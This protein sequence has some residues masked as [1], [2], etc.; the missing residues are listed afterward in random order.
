ML[1]LAL[2]LSVFC[3]SVGSLAWSL[4]L[5]MSLNGVAM[6]GMNRGTRVDS[7]ISR[8]NITLGTSHVE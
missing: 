5:S 6:A 4:L 3:T 2:A 7:I 8:T 1:E